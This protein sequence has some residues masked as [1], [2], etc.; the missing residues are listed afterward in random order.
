[1]HRDLLPW[2]AGFG[3]QQP[4]YLIAG[5]IVATFV[6][7]TMLFLAGFLTA[8]EDADVP[9][10]VFCGSGAAM[11]GFGLLG[12][13]VFVR[14]IRIDATAHRIDPALLYHLIRFYRAEANRRPE[15]GT[16]AALARVREGDLAV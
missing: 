7:G 5:A 1:M 2:P 12:L 11:C 6:P 15:L 10:A 9:L 16:E 3:S 4:R 14:E 13:P 8:V